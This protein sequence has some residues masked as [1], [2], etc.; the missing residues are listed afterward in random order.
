MIPYGKHLIDEDDIA[1]VIS[2]LRSDFLTQGEMVPQF[3][4]AVCA[5]VGARHGVAV[6]SAT[7]AL[8]VAC[9][10]LNLSPGD[11][12][13]TSSISFVASANCGL[14]CG[15]T[16]DF[17]DIDPKTFNISVDLLERKLI[18]AEALGKLPKLLIVVHMAG[19]SCDMVS[20]RALGD[21]YG[22]SI[23]EDAS[24]ALG[25]RYLNLPIGSCQYSDITIFSFHPVKI[26]TS[27][28]GGMAVTNNDLLAREMQLLRSHGITR[29]PTEMV[30]KSRQPVCYEQIT[31]GFNY[32][33]TDIHAAIGL[34]QL[35]KLDSFV[36]RRND[37]A[38]IYLN[39][40]AALPL[41]TQRRDTE[42]YSA[43]HLFIIQPYYRDG[44]R[45]RDLMLQHLLSKGIICNIH[46][47]PIMAHPYFNS[48]GFDVNDYPN[49]LH[50]YQTSLSI[51]IFP[52]MAE[53][54]ITLC[55]DSVTDFLV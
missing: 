37:I 27:G 41:S 53:E 44:S 29:D 42:S 21:R 12:F 6:N 20:I 32:R 22:F 46:Y 7:S 3:E 26:I 47:R 17:V 16:V 19:L 28:E 18:I 1:S 52:G 45:S 40:F 35:N 33:M 55:I 23:I 25:G 4:R 13:W 9:L 51:P 11:I 34:S 38:N 31:L 2:V 15:A 43:Y 49:A 50:Y 39:R 10:A 24:H 30:E 36:T 54:E 48:L 5:R 8:H 14:Y